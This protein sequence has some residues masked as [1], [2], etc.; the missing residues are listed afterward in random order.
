[1]GFIFYA[2]LAPRLNKMFSATE[3]KWENQ[4][5]EE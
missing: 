4:D 5:E 2:Y 1:M 3:K